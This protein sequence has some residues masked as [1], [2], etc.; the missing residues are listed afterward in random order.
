LGSAIDELEDAAP[1]LFGFAGDDL[2]GI[3]AAARLSS[4]PVKGGNR[5]VFIATW[6]MAL[7]VSCWTQLVSQGLLAAYI[8]HVSLHVA[9]RSFEFFYL[10]VTFGQKIRWLQRP[11]AFDQRNPF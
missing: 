9:L 6:S 4:C 7:V 3:V 10:T 11:D 8:R 5:S 1:L 2:G